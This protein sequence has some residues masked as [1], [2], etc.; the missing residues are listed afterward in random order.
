MVRL[1]HLGGVVFM[2]AKGRIILILPCSCKGKG[3]DWIG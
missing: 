2:I 3:S 1:M